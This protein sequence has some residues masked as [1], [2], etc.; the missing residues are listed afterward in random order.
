MAQVTGPEGLWE[1]HHC[2]FFPHGLLEPAGA[3]GA[4]SPARLVL[5]L[6]LVSVSSEQRALF[7]LDSFPLWVAFLGPTFITPLF[8][9]SL[10]LF[11]V[12]INREGRNFLYS[13]TYSSMIVQEERWE[14]FKDLKTLFFL[15]QLLYL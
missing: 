9:F 3:L 14:L 13:H 1:S 7:C 10:S 5:T 15:N 12:L 11:G 2:V 8:L 6:I 4:R